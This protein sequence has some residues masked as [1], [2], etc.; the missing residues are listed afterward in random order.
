V[1]SADNGNGL[2]SAGSGNRNGDTQTSANQ[3]QSNTAVQGNGASAGPAKGSCN[4]QPSSGPSQSN[5]AA[6]GNA[7]GLQANVAPQ[8]QVLSAD[9]GNGLIASNSGNRN[10]DT[11]TSANQDQSN[12]TVQGNGS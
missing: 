2:I 4:Q 9:N 8:V 7:Q 1:L 6:Q 11:Q 3:D 12:T 5:G 10:G